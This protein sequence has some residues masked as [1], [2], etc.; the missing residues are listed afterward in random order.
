MLA[1][2]VVAA[3]FETLVTAVV[4]LSIAVEPFSE[5]PFHAGIVLKTKMDKLLQVQEFSKLNKQIQN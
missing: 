3:L 2:V 1:L 5:S 4:A